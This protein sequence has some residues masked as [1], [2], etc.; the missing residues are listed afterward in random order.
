MDSLIGLTFLFNMHADGELLFQCLE[1]FVH[2]VKFIALYSI[3]AD[4]ILANSCRCKKIYFLNIVG[5]HY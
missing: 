3:N 5:C 2:A 1:A 4:S